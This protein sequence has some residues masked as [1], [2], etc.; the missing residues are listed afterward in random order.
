MNTINKLNKE[1]NKLNKQY[2][3]L[4]KEMDLINKSDKFACTDHLSQKLEEI[5]LKMYEISTEIEK[6]ENI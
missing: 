4:D 3:S 2:I 6:L 1:L 5:N